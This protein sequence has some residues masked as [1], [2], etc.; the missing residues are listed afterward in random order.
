MRTIACREP[1]QSSFP[2]FAMAAM[3]GAPEAFMRVERAGSS[4]IVSR[5]RP[6]TRSASQ[7][8]SHGL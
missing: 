8:F 2:S 4:G 3:V 7:R 6:E 5:R 1:F